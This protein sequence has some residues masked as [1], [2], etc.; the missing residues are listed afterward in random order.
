MK[1]LNFAFKNLCSY[2]NKLQSFTFSEDPQ[3]ILVEGKSGD[4]KSTISDALTF[5]A[6]G[7]SSIRATKELPNRMNKNGY[8]Y[9]NFLTNSG[10]TVEVERG[11]EP[12]FS[13]LSLDGIEHN[14]PDKRRVDEFIEE[15][16]IKIPF[17]VFSNTI[18]LSINDFKSFVKLSPNDRRQIVDKI[19]GMDIV[20]DMCKKMKEESKNLRL[21]LSTL[22]SSITNNRLIL[23]NS[24]DQLAN[25]KD[26]LTSMKTSRL[27]EL[28]ESIKKLNDSKEIY[29]IAYAKINE[30]VATL[31]VD[32]IKARDARVAS[33]LSIADL[34]KKLQLYD[35]NK[36]PFCLSDLTDTGHINIKADLSKTK[37]A[38]EIGLSDLSKKAADAQTILDDKKRELG[39]AREKFYQV[40]GQILPLK[41]EFSE[42]RMADQDKS[43]GPEYLNNAISTINTALLKADGERLIITDQLRISQEMEEILSD[44]GMKR[45]LMNEIV[46][47]LNTK[48][49]R[50][51]KILEFKYQFEFDMDFDPIITHLGIQ[52]SPKSLSTG[53]EKKMNLIV[54]LCIIELI[55][56]KH[57]NVNLL[58]LDEIFSSLDIESIYRVIDLLRTFSKKYK[59][60]I[61]VISHNPL[62]A[63]L[64]DRKLSVETVDYF[65]DITFS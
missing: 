57:N 14:L 53:E 44:T 50:T 3:L 58:F 18:S 10:T 48:I 30:S 4:G 51:A 12:N 25:M 15:E 8:T 27:A 1:I 28:T 56:L 52:I 59:M 64:F 7:K 61:F 31:E 35:N 20:N 37:T 42:L 2:G 33:Q 39:S 63:V 43:A 36:C 23:Q 38:K 54:L 41:R 19:F 45:V 55:K 62:P 21:A 6:Y 60:T 26:D 46:P 22:D 32:V 17:N 16:L 9:M 47:V 11:L 29:R 5:A 40:D 24:I 34:Q 13:R 49:L 65:S